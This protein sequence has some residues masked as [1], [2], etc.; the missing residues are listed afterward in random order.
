MS[1]P[2]RFTPI[3]PI[4]ICLMLASTVQ[5]G[6][7]TGSRSDVETGGAAKSPEVTVNP[8]AGPL[9]ELILPSASQPVDPTNYSEAMTGDIDTVEVNP[10]G[11]GDLMWATKG[12]DDGVSVPGVVGSPAPGAVHGRTYNDPNL[13]PRISDDRPTIIKWI[14]SVLD[15]AGLSKQCDET[16][17][18]GEHRR[19]PWSGE[20]HDR[21]VFK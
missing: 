12:T 17:S 6:P 19:V 14:D 3:A 16:N 20:C 13:L 21:F 5:A 15:A 11:L 1:N 7:L 2:L 9:S 10:R 8:S 18:R 4:V